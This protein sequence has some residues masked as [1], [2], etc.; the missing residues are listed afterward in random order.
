MRYFLIVII[1][2]LGGIFMAF[3]RNNK[4]VDISDI[5]DFRFFYT[6]G[7]AVNS[8]VVY[9]LNCDEEC[10]AIYKA[11]GKSSEEA[12]S[13]SI[14]E[15]FIKE[16][17]NIFNKYSIINW[18]GFHKSNK[19]VLDGD[20]FSLNIHFLDGSSISASGYMS[21]PK[22]YGDFKKEIDDLFKRVFK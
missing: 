13:V 16:V 2:I 8:D 12:V 7:Y 5:K 15:E 6:M 20:S 10:V 9:E 18:D 19:N 21:Y 11:Y 14:D 4:K 22:N 17:I 1:V 3:Y